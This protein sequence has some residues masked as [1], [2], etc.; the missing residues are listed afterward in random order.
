MLKSKT[1]L[2]VAVKTA[3][4]ATAG[5]GIFSAF[6]ALAS[7]YAAPTPVTYNCTLA[8]AASPSATYTFTMDLTGP[9]SAVVNSPLV[10]TWKISAPATLPS[11]TPSVS[12]SPSASVV[13]DAE[14]QISASPAGVLTPPTELR[15]I[16]VTAAPPANGQPV[17]APPLLVTVTPLATGVVAFQPGAFT[18]LRAT[19][20][21]GAS[22]EVELLDCAAPDAAQASPAALRVTVGTGSPSASPSPTTTSPTPTPTNTSAT[23]TPTLTVT[24]TKTS[25]PVPDPDSDEQIDETPKGAASTGGGGDAGPDARMIMFSGVLMVALAGIGGLVLRRRTAGRG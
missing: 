19:G 10:A 3:V 11:L 25:D 14:V 17:T 21:A 20:A 13:A 4:V 23:P 16:L 8:G 18:L 1:R 9:A 22:N 6:P 7:I 15:P 2:R 5:A 24:R 12:V